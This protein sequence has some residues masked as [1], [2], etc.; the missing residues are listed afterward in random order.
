MNI[1]ELIAQLEAKNEGRKVRAYVA[2]PYRSPSERGLFENIHRARLLAE[3]LWVRG[4]A[5]FCPHLN[6]A[7]MGGIVTDTDFIAGDLAWLECADL[8]VMV[9]GWQR[10][11]GARAEYGYAIERGITVVEAQQIVAPLTEAKPSEPSV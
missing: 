7:F 3:F 4:L 10:S 5:V 6:T 11:E 1:E 8:V 9:P 2:G